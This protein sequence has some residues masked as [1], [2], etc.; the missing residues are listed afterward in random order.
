MIEQ[1]CR[2]DT[3]GYRNGGRR[4]QAS[5]LPLETILDILRRD[6]VVRGAVAD[7]AAA[8]ALTPLNLG[9]TL[10][11]EYVHYPKPSRDV[12]IPWNYCAIPRLF[13]AMAP[14]VAPFCP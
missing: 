10:L 11:R 9:L 8:R 7:H 4:L 3:L 6:L 13:P 14:L 2:R 1:S 12:L 5:V